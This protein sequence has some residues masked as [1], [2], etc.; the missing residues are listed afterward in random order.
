MAVKQSNVEE[1]N[2]P[3]S[4]SPTKSNAPCTGSVNIL[5]DDEQTPVTVV[6]PKSLAFSRLKVFNKPGR[7]ECEV[8]GKINA[9]K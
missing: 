7:F 8:L 4:M 5:W 9:R 1:H 6:K 2:V 3:L